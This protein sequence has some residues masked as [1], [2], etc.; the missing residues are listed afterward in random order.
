MKTRLC[1]VGNSHIGALRRG[2]CA[3]EES[4]PGVEIDMFGAAGPLFKDIVVADGRLQAGS[5]AARASFLATGGRHEAPLA[6]YDAIVVV[7][8]SVRIANIAILLKSHCPPFMNAALVAQGDGDRALRV[9][10]ARFYRKEAPIIVSNAL[11]RE[12]MAAR[13]AQGMALALCRQISAATRVPVYHVPTPFPSS[14]I[15]T[16]KPGNVVAQLVA[17]GVGA[18]CA[19]LAL[20]SLRIALGGAADVIEPPAHVLRDGILTDG[21]YSVG[22]ARLNAKRA[23]H[24]DEDMFH[25]NA[26]YGRVMMDEILGVAQ[27]PRASSAA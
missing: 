13:A 24:D 19:R 3:I 27:A 4:H 21:A 11:L 18:A 25:M 22:G 15:V 1:L 26:D 8:G 20:S 14:D 23:D 2:W 6:D 17:L 10:L 5:E 16:R 9:G 7:G 12:V